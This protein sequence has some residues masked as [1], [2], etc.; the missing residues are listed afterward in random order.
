MKFKHI[1]I[2]ALSVLYISICS[3]NVFSENG[4]EKNTRAKDNKEHTKPE[5]KPKIRSGKRG[6]IPTLEEFEPS[7]E[8][9]AD[10]SVAFPIDI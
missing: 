5:T 2:A 4:T 10:K 7:E 6:E 9:S 8:V 1:I 3:N